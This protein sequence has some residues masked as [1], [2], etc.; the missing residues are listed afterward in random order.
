[1]KR[2]VNLTLYVSLQAETGN[3]QEKP[4]RFGLIVLLR[5]E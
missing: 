4:S 5:L 1:M 3:D 2:L